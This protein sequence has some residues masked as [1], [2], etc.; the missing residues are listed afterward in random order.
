MAKK[1]VCPVCG[2]QIFLKF[3][4]HKYL[5]PWDGDSYI[6]KNV[7]KKCVKVAI[8]RGLYKEPEFVK[9]RYDFNKI[10]D[11]KDTW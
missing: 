6:G 3:H 8:K 9:S 5:Y 7:H 2:E 1:L 4:D 11:E 10:L